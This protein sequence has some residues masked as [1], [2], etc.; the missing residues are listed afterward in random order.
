L[1]ATAVWL[2]VLT[3][4]MP[5]AFSQDTHWGPKSADD[6]STALGIMSRLPTLR[7]TD[8]DV[9][10]TE[11]GLPSAVRSQGW[12]E[13]SEREKLHQG[14]RWARAV[15]EENGYAFLT[16]TAQSFAKRYESVQFD[17]IL[18]SLVGRSAP[19][20]KVQFA[21]P[22]Q[23]QMAQ[24]LPVEIS[25]ALDRLQH[26]VD[27]PG[28]LGRGNVARHFFGLEGDALF[29]TLEARDPRTFL[30]QASRRAPVP[31]ELRERIASLMREVIRQ[32][33]AGSQDR[34]LAQVAEQLI[35]RFGEPPG[36]A[37]QLAGNAFS[38]DREDRLH[39]EPPQYPGTGDPGG[40]S[41]GAAGGGGGTPEREKRAQEI[42]RTFESEHY[43][44]PGARSFL[45]AAGRAG[46][47]GGVLAGSPVNGIALGKP[48]SV[49]IELPAGAIC[50]DAGQPPV[51]GQV[52]LRT[53]TGEYRLPHLRCDVMF[54]ARRL[55]FDSLGG[56]VWSPGDALGLAAVD[57]SEKSAAFPFFLPE[58]GSLGDLAR[59]RRVV[60]HPALLDL[61]IG[62]SAAVLDLWPNAPLALLQS[63]AEDSN[64][65]KWLRAK[66]GTATWKWLDS[67]AQLSRGQGDIVVTPRGRRTLLAFRGFSDGD[68]IIEKLSCEGP[69]QSEAAC[70]SV[71]TAGGAGSMVKAFDAAAPRLVS[72][73]QEFADVES[74]MRTLSVFRWAREN[75]VRT[76]AGT[77]SMAGQDR[78]AKTPDSVVFSETGE[79]IATI[80]APADWKRDCRDFMTRFEQ[81]RSAGEAAQSSVGRVVAENIVLPKLKGLGVVA[82]D[83][84]TGKLQWQC[85]S[86]TR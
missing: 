55:V 31:P 6:V 51:Y 21:R 61:P 45:A 20:K 40:G 32:S 35:D 65:A 2:L 73:V 43:A 76:V 8:L 25:A 67:P 37:A 85:A 86:S 48:V 36:R 23:T 26:Y 15:S 58:G 30:D 78:R 62:R 1:C 49:A 57:F 74:L 13:L 24:P 47:R 5:A 33:D 75:G 4:F 27:K 7:P 68:L 69:L 60:L 59:R 83:P 39:P 38:I 63:T 77:V 28:P 14:Y 66:E 22:T 84:G 34:V 64:V 70:A 50:A 44:R 82:V 11:V 16:A 72:R 53:N 3:L 19:S 79:W 46:G 71:Q 56:I 80:T 9:V 54:A 18:G 12:R 81:A 17:P 10:M 29:D 52:V 41:G 42:H